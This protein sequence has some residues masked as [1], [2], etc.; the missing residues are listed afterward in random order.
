MKCL[1]G[2]LVILLFSLGCDAGRSQNT[3]HLKT[4]TAKCK[5][6][7]DVLET[8]KD[9]PSAKAAAPKLKIVMQELHKLDAQIETTYDPEEV[10]FVDSPRMTKQV[11]EG[12]AEMQR[13]MLESVRVGRD[14]EL[15]AAL[16]DTWQLLPAEA[17]MDAQGNLPRP[18]DRS[19]PASRLSP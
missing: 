6:A 19:L 4:W 2:L 1:A 18:S 17:M 16:G 9:V 10:D 14:P 12:I 8:I 5:E 3:R 15:R 13:M 7:A 11:G